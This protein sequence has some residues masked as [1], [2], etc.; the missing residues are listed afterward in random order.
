MVLI[1]VLSGEREIGGNFIRI[2]DKDRKIIFDQGIRFSVLRRY[3]SPF[4]QPM[5]IPELR[6][7]NAL[8][9]SEWYE[10]CEAVYISHLHLD[11]L[12]SLGSIPHQITVFVPNLNV[13][14]ALE[15]EWEKSP[16]W[17]SLIPR[18]YL[19]SVKESTIFKTDKCNVQG[20][21]VS[22]SA[23][24][25]CAYIYFGSDETILYTGDFRIE[26]LIENVEGMLLEFFET[27]KDIKVDTMILEATNFGRDA[28]PIGSKEALKIFEYL[29]KG[30]TLGLVVCH[31]LDVETFTA[32]SEV[33]N[34]LRLKPI[35]ASDRLAKTVEI[36]QMKIPEIEVLETVKE[37]VRFPTSFIK[38]LGR[39]VIFLSERDLIELLNAL[40]VEGIMLKG[41]PVILAETEPA[42][43]ELTEFGRILNWLK[44]YGVQPYRIR[45][46]GHYYP[47]QLKKLL[48]IVKPKNIKPVHTENPEM[49]YT[50]AEK[51]R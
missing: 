24:P 23:Y 41:I 18:N 12:G 14:E 15:R 5:G 51:F 7:L 16:S 4:I 47:Y 6:N 19:V 28:S 20:I 34:K 45:V 33:A 30:E 29:L 49:V 21:F 1:K 13:F 26:S 31:P 38:R 2:E 3:Y 40:H 48:K 11:H 9:K 37:L 27:N 46:S 39:A 35:I 10:G 44:Y 25:A 36:S 17:L 8:P 42:E 22:H 43:E 50:I 32:F